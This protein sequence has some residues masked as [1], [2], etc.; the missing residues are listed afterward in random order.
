MRTIQSKLAVVFGVFLI[1]GLLGIVIVVI[2]SRQDD[3]KMINLAGKQ[4]ML[5][6]KMSKESIALMQGRGSNESLNR[7]VNQFESVLNGLIAGDKELGLTPVNNVSITNQLQHIQKIWVDF[8]IK[9]DIVSTNAVETTEALSYINNN[10]VTLLNEMNKAVGMLESKISDSAIINLAGKQRMLTQKMTKEAIALGSGL[11]QGNESVD[12]LADTAYLF[13]KTLK[14]LIY[15][16]KDMRLSEITD[17]AALAQLTVVQGLWNTFYENVITVQKLAPE[18]NKAMDYIND[19]NVRLLKEMNMVVGMY[20]SESHKRTA[21]IQWANIVVVIVTVLTVF[22]AWILVVRPMTNLLCNL[23]IKLTEGSTQ[24]AQASE[25][26]SASSHNLAQGSS[27]QA[28]SLEETSASME[29]MTSMTKQNAD[30]SREAA[31]IAEQ[32]NKNAKTSTK[33]VNEMNDAMHNINDSSKKIG[34]IIKV[35]DGIAFQTNLLALNAAVEA[36]RAGEHGKGFAVV[37]EEVRNLAQRS[38]AAARDTTELIE[39]C[40]SKAEVGTTLSGEC[41]TSLS[42]IV[43]N[44]KKVTSLINEISVASTEQSDGIDQVSKAIHEMD[45]VTQQNA[46]TAEESASA[47]EELSAQS[48]NLL[49]QVKSLSDQIGLDDS[50]SDGSYDQKHFKSGQSGNQSASNKSNANGQTNQVDTNGL[51]PMGENRIPEHDESM[52]VC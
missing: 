45:Q 1:L 21:M 12:T 33:S 27:E 39:D 11:V 35:I 19:Y 51:I 20:E 43:G 29:E 17:N 3:G 26:I 9:L 47:S 24:V 42:D 50:G 46:A 36:A 22:V 41:K 23:V 38:A 25:Q 32:C 13:D 16:D 15:G 34:D 5:T 48:Q 31:K 4:R 40:I 8:K 44:V 2:S 14:R 52:S 10:N 7:T 37:A 6:Q 49:E 28:S 30:N 18:S